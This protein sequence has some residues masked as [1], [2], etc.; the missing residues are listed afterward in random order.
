MSFIHKY[1]YFAINLRFNDNRISGDLH[2]PVL[3][4]KITFD[5]LTEMV[6]I[7]DQIMQEVNIPKEDAKLTRLDV[8]NRYVKRNIEYVELN[9]DNFKER[10]IV[11]LTCR[12]KK[13]NIFIIKVMYKQHNTWQ[14]EMNLMAERKPSFFKSASEMVQRIRFDVKKSSCNYA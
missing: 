7:M 9:Q 10:L 12:G 4:E 2:S 11:S 3:L 14:G 13:Q 8:E 6:Q 1:M 5:N